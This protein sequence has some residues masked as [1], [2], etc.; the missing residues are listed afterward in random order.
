MLVA[1][2]TPKFIVPA[3]TVTPPAGA[4]TVTANPPPCSAAV[5]RA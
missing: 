4:D 1:L 3:A 5:H 2:A